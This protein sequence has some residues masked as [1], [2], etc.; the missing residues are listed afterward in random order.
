MSNPIQQHFIP[1]TYLKFFTPNRDGKKL[2]VLNL[3]DPFQRKVMARDSGDS[4]FCGKKYYNS[5]VFGDPFFLEK[6]FAQHIEAQYQD[7]VQIM[8]KEKAITELEIKVK[9]FTWI[10]YN[11]FRSPVVRDYFEWELSK[12]KALSKQQVAAFGKESHLRIF[13]DEKLFNDVLS[14]MMKVMM[15]KRWEILKTSDDQPFITCDSPGYHIDLANVEQ[16]GA[17]KVQPSP[18]LHKLDV[19]SA[20]F[21]P[22]TSNYLLAVSPYPPGTPVEKNLSNTAVIFRQISKGEVRQ[23]NV[24]T[25]RSTRH[26]LIGANTTF[27]KE[28]EEMVRVAAQKPD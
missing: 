5:E 16:L 23:L 6:F 26:L 4:I 15:S 24:F 20:V 13:T 28:I 25:M 17:F 11:K 8:E 22:L 3:K 1:K 27:L 18:F 14:E 12:Y 10:F 21:F 7:L 9:L 2:Q 19:D